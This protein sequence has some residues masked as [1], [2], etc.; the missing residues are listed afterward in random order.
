[1]KTLLQINSGIHGAESQTSKLADEVAHRLLAQ[2]SAMRHIKR[3]LSKDP[4][5]HL[6]KTTFLS[7]SAPATVTSAT[8][9]EGLA[10]SDELIAELRETDVLLVGAPMYNFTIPSTL[11]S[12]IDHVTRAGETFRFT[13]EGPKGLLT[14]IRAIIVIAQGGD[15]LGT[16]MDFETGYLELALGHLGITDIEFIH[17]KGLA[18]GQ[19]AAQAGLAAARAQIVSLVGRD[20]TPA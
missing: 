20:L 9:I 17:A 4:I 8:K 3:D 13:N 18:L 1:M 2:H 14:G 15:F 12:W 16:S 6:D 10:I 5:P 19:E 11:K 7:F